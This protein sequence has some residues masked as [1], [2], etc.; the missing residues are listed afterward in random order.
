[1]KMQTKGYLYD[2]IRAGLEL[3][4]DPRLYLKDITNFEVFEL[5][6]FITTANF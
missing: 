6:A 3:T 1:M 5:K 4:M 2:E